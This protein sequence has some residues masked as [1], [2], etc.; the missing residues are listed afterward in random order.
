MEIKKEINGSKAK[1]SI[2]G[3]L[4]T[5]TAPELKA[6]LDALSSEITELEID[7]KELEYISSAGLRQIVAAHTKM[8]GNFELTNVSSEIM[9]VLK[10]T[11]LNNVLIIK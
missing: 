3:W 10:M 6:E 8:N 4:D 9:Y 5:Q 1:L 7:C 11:G 2:I